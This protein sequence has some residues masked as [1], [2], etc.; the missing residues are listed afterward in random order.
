MCC[1]IIIYSHRHGVL[2]IP[3]DEGVEVLDGQWK[4]GKMTG[5][6]TVK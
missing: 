1:I 4:E 3:K 5:L 2:S 6:G